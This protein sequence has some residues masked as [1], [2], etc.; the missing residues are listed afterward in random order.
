[1]QIFKTPNFDFVRWRWHAIVLSLVIIGIGMAKIATQGMPL[2][3]EFEGG[4]IVILKFEQPPDVGRI[5]DALAAGIP[6]G[7]EAVVQ[8]YGTADQNQVSIRT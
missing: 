4:T 5:R 7:G 3:V 2:G 8:R 6:G 1:M